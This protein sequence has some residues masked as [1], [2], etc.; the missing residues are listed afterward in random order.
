MWRWNRKSAGRTVLWL[1]PLVMIIWGVYQVAD[2]YASKAAHQDATRMLFEASS[3][4]IE[5]MSRF[6]SEAKGIKSSSELSSLTNAVY[7][8]SYVHER[9]ARVFPMG[10]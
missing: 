9:F 1:I 8:A 3:F 10:R 2:L 4:Q 5:L 6:L 7:S